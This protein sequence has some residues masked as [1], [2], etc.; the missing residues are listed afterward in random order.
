MPREDHPD[1]AVYSKRVRTHKLKSTP[2]YLPRRDFF[3][4]PETRFSGQPDLIGLAPKVCCC[5]LILYNLYGV[6]DNQVSSI[7]HRA[8]KMSFVADCS[9]EG[10]AV[11]R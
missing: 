11:I 9:E 3:C 2:R 4:W 5:S 7:S 8:T 10:L 6:L 1:A